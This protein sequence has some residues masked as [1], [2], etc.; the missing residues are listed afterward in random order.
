MLCVVFFLV[1]ICSSYLTTTHS[2]S[3]FTSWNTQ[4]G[5][6]I[7]LFLSHERGSTF[8]ITNH[9]V[10]ILWY[11]SAFQKWFG[12]LS[13][14]GNIIIISITIGFDWEEIVILWVTIVLIDEEHRY[15]DF[16][17][18]RVRKD[19]I[20]SLLCRYSHDYLMSSMNLR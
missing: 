19:V 9:C 4:Y 18:L 8:R 16:H 7:I 13:F 10:Y 1:F 6:R 5:I 3:S 2:V 11:I 15:T 17:F 14:R 12:R 20:A